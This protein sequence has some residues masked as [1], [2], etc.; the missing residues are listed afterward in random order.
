MDHH[1]AL[2]MLAVRDR[3]FFTLVDQD[4]QD[5]LHV[6]ELTAQQAALARLAALV[7]LDGA[8]VSYIHVV[9]EALSAGA[10]VDDLVG[11]LIAVMPSTG[12][13]RV[14]SAAPKLALA[15]GY[16]IDAALEV[17]GG[18]RRRGGI[19]AEQQRRPGEEADRAPEG[20]RGVEGGVQQ[21]AGGRLHPSRDRRGH[22]EEQRAEQ[23]HG[24]CPPVDPAHLDGTAATASRTCRG[25]CHPLRVNVHPVAAAATVQGLPGL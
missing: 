9:E 4:E 18:L 14:V 13:D 23:L 3:A 1:H 12:A 5:N 2:L 15:L 19:G 22:V 24:G 21:I 20:A 11:T 10:S 17:V 16:D 8:Q 25:A 6:S 7:A